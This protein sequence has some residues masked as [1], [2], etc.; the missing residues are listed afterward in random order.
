MYN[1]NV[2]LQLMQ[3]SLG[4]YAT[5]RTEEVKNELN[6]ELKSMPE[7]NKDSYLMTDVTDKFIESHLVNPDLENITTVDE[8]RD[9]EFFSNIKNALP[10]HT[11]VPIVSGEWI[12]AY[13]FH[14]KL[15]YILKENDGY[16]GENIT[17]YF[18]KY[19]PKTVDKNIV[20]IVFVAALPKSTASQGTIFDMFSVLPESIDDDFKRVSFFPYSIITVTPKAN[21]I[22]KMKLAGLKFEDNVDTVK[23]VL[24]TDKGEFNIDGFAMYSNTEVEEAGM[25]SNYSATNYWYAYKEYKDVTVSDIVYEK[26]EGTIFTVVSQIKINPVTF[27]ETKIEEVY[28]DITE[29][30]SIGSKVR[31]TDDGSIVKIY[32]PKSDNQKLPKCEHCG[33]QLEFT[34]TGKLMCTNGDCK[35]YKIEGLPTG[36]NLPYAQLWEKMKVHLKKQDEP[37]GLE[38]GLF[39][40]EDWIIDDVIYV[41]GK[42]R[43]QDDKNILEA[44]RKSLTDIWNKLPELPKVEEPQEEAKEI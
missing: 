7:F 24:K 19:L 36:Q 18:E 35:L 26:A 12:G 28:G 32:E 22:D 6:E 41:F 13:Y 40:K 42:R 21:F 14:G 27:G 31:I 11:A 16:T 37:Q 44:Y 38:D 2:K 4:M 8:Y 9:P 15:K 34:S 1:D 39:I 5:T 25:N 33:K 10:N 29:G 3:E 20:K 17:K 23:G 43:K 30:I